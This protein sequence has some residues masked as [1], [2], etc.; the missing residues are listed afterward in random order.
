MFFL[1]DYTTPSTILKSVGIQKAAMSPKKKKLFGAVQHLCKKLKKASG[2][3][4]S[5]KKRLFLAKEFMK[6]KNV[7]A[8]L[9]QLNKMSAQ[10]IRSQ[11][12]E[13][14][15]NPKSHRFTADEKIL[16]LA[17]Y[18]QSPKTYRFLANIFTLPSKGTLNNFLKKV[19]FEPGINE[20]IFLVLKKI[21]T[22]WKQSQKY[23]S[24]I[25]DEMSLMPNLSFN[26]CNGCIEGFIDMGK[27]VRKEI[28]DHGLLFMVTGIQKKFKF[29]LGYVF[30][31]NGGASALQLKPIIE[32]ILEKLIDIGLTPIVTV[33]D[34]ATAN[35]KLVNMLIDQT[36]E[37][38]IRN[39]INHTGSFFEVKNLQIYPIFDPPHLLK[40]IRNNF[41]T[42]N[43]RYKID[44]V[45]RTAK[46]DHIIKLYQS[47]NGPNTI[48]GLRILPYLTDQHVYSDKIKKMK[49]KYA[50]QIFSHRLA[51]SLYL[52]A[53]IGK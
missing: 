10:F 12:R 13:V 49:V 33:C 15:K 31:G 19:K 42:K 7:E 47:D 52:A 32:N 27:G 25:W 26:E 4:A 23:V 20:N 29:P 28:A 41:L 53:R 51:S 3:K 8:N 50:A 30:T 24:L 21:I 16:A 36:N 38:Y 43:I 9:A 45:T 39:G 11:I 1:V 34:Q 5:F 18:K 37:H 14:G 2:S 17:I 22:K 48:Q 46:W 6:D 35:V 40:G 44:N